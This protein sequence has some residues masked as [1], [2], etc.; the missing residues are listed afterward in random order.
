MNRKALGLSVTL[1]ALAGLVGACG[2]SSM[3]GASTYDA[4][5]GAAQISGEGAYLPAREM[6]AVATAE[7]PPADLGGGEHQA[8]AA[9]TPLPDAVGAGAA[10]RKIIK[11]A[12]M[13]IEVDSVGLGLS[14]ID[15]IAAQAGGYVIE[16]RT[17]FADALRKR[18]FIK[19]AV[20][21]GQ[22]ES[23]LQRIREASGKV[24]S[25][26][27]SGVD[28]SQ[29]YVDVQSQIANLEATQARVRAFLDDAKTVEEALNVNQRLTEIEGQ[30]GQAKG[31]LQYLSQRSAF[32]TIAVDLQEKEAPPT[33]TPTPTPR[34]PWQAGQ[35]A[36]R[37]LDALAVWLQAL[38]DLAIWLLL[39]VLPV[40]LIV[41]VPV[42]LIWW[43]VRAIR[44]R[45]AR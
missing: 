42:A 20:P 43:A 21:V 40:V 36:G 35:T 26:E 39:V 9:A 16:T 12:T 6:A 31:R 30:L 8:V 44:R 13:A 27:A 45:R 3:S 38:A 5:S 32:S 17:D 34:P 4:P 7:A 10:I 11:D 2:Q 18:A 24:L 23:V 25:E 41:A 19:I 29:E 14:R 15:G 1:L 37:A 33:V 28:V 22:F